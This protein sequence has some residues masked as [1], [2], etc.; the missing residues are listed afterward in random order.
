MKKGDRIFIFFPTRGFSCS[1]ENI[2]QSKIKLIGRSTQS[3]YSLA[4]PSEH[5][6]NVVRTLSEEVIGLSLSTGEERISKGGRNRV[7]GEAACLIS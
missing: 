7:A 1:G 4:L 2:Q 3:S 6:Q 5:H